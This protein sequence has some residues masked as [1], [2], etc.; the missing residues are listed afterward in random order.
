MLAAAADDRLIVVNPGKGV[1]LPRPDTVEIVPP[2]GEAVRALYEAAPD[3]FRVAVVLGA[4][5]GLRQGEASGLTAD[6]IDWLAGRSARIDRQW[7]S[8]TAVEFAPLKSDSSSRTVPAAASVL[9]ELARAVDGGRGSV[10]VLHRDGEPV[11]HHAFEYAW[12]QTVKRAGLGDVLRFHALRHRFAS[13]LISGGCSI[14][15]VQRAM[16]HST[17]SITLGVYGHMMPSDT[18]RIRVALEGVFGS[19]EDSL[20]TG[21]VAG[22]V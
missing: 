20:R 13:A 4:G 10:F 19:A 11:G 12:R 22:Q 5:L 2:T 9:T 21:G 8:R 6:R 14:V 17:P 16:G 1:R 3:W 7:T 18:D 15:A